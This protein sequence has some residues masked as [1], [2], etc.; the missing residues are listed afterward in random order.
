MSPSTS[1]QRRRSAK[2]TRLRGPWQ[3]WSE[4]LRDELRRRLLRKRSLW[5]KAAALATAAAVAGH[6]STARKRSDGPAAARAAA[7]A[8]TADA[9]FAATPAW[10]EPGGRSVVLGSLKKFRAGYTDK[11]HVYNSALLRV[12]NSCREDLRTK[13]AAD[14]RPQAAA[15]RDRKAQ[16]KAQAAAQRA[17]VSWSAT[18]AQRKR[19]WRGL[20]A[21]ELKKY[22]RQ[23]KPLAEDVADNDAGLPAPDPG[24]FVELWEVWLLGH[25]QGVRV[26]AAAAPGAHRLPAGGPSGDPAKSLQELPERRRQDL[27]V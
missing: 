3:K 13:A 27:P 15:R 10:T 17:K 20:T 2:T 18:L 6:A 12:P 4:P 25:L 21:E 5:R 8:P 22:K 11:S 26:A 1:A 24:K 16:R 9:S 14:V 7:R 23:V 19:A